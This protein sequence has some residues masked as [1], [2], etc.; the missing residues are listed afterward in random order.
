M[1]KVSLQ[2]RSLNQ[3][4]NFYRSQLHKFEVIGIGNKT[5][6]DVVITQEL[7][8]ITLKR[9]EQLSVPV[10]LRKRKLVL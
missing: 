7:I 6:N 5:E 9:L 3:I 4:C 1:T 8:D 10:S 2:S